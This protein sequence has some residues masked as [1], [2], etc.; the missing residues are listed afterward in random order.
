M[1]QLTDVQ[2]VFLEKVQLLDKSREYTFCNPWPITT[3]N[4]LTRGS[5]DVLEQHN[6]NALGKQYT[7]W[8]INEK[9]N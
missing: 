8:L 4:V 3:Y 2:R 9:H 5:Y 6:L 7:E 1:T